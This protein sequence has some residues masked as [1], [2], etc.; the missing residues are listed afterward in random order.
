LSSGNKCLPGHRLNVS[1]AAAPHT[2][3]QE[4]VGG[5][6]PDEQLVVLH[7]FR[8]IQRPE[9]KFTVPHGMTFALLMQPVRFMIPGDLSAYAFPDAGFPHGAVPV[10]DYQSCFHHHSPRMRSNSGD[11][12]CPGPGLI[13]LFPVSPCFAHISSSTWSSLFRGF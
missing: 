5:S 6:Y 2:V 3:I 9:S 11:V 12:P 8:G 4:W 13:F 7:A 10:N 1:F